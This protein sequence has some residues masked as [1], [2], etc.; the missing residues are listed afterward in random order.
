MQYFS[1]EHKLLSL[2]L[3]V[4]NRV[5]GVF[6]RFVTDD[7]FDVEKVKAVFQER[8]VSK[9]RLQTA[10][11]TLVGAG[12][13]NAQGITQA[14]ISKIQAIETER[15]LEANRLGLVG[16]GASGNP[17]QAL[18]DELNAKDY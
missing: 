15:A 6:E 1:P 7:V 4:H 17:S 9:V 2:L 11:Q 12:F 3:K 16:F 18:I 13:A 5:P 14:G 10:V 8:G